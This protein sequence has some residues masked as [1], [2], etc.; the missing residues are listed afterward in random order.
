[1]R[2]VVGSFFNGLGVCELV[3]PLCK[4]FDA[5]NGA[6]TSCFSGY[7]VTGGG[8]CEKSKE[9][10]RDAYCAEF[11]EGFCVKCS[12]GYY[13]ERDGKCTAADPLCATFDPMD[14]R[15]LT[16]FLGYEVQSGLCILKEEDARDPNCASFNPDNTCK[17]CSKG[18][19]FNQDTKNCQ[20]TNPLCKTI[21]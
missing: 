11:Q 15:C 13:F 1:M 5:L 4:T 16:C 7:E 14:G 17:Q 18:F 2:C 19:V 8:Q 20:L 9:E 10:E 21:D 12:N 6:C 3:N